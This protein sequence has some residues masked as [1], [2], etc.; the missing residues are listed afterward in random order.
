MTHRLKGTVALVN[1]EVIHGDG[2]QYVAGPVVCSG[3]FG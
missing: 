3:K 1:G 2:S